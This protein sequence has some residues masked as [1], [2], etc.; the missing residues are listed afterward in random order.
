MDLEAKF[1]TCGKTYDLIKIELDS[2]EIKEVYFEI[3]KPWLEEYEEGS[4]SSTPNGR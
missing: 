4:L 1:L 2:G 3:T